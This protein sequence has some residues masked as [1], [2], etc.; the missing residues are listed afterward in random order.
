[1]IDYFTDGGFFEWIWTGFWILIGFVICLSILVGPAVRRA[2]RI[3]ELEE[4]LDE[5]RGTNDIWRR[6]IAV[7]CDDV[8]M[9]DHVRDGL[10]YI[11]SRT[12]GTP[13]PVMIGGR[14]IPEDLQEEEVTEATEEA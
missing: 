8:P 12:V 3:R 14:W 4:R 10:I 5:E 9:E 7:M 6:R 13:K 11:I 2:Y 1:M